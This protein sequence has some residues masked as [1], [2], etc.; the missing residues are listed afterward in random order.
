MFLL[1]QEIKQ[2][3]WLQGN[4]QGME[5]GGHR[6][7]DQAVRLRLV[8]DHMPTNRQD[9]LRRESQVDLLYMGSPVNWVIKAT[10]WHLKSDKCRC[11][12]WCG[13]L[14]RYHYICID[15]ISS[16]SAPLWD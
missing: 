9:R 12:M 2:A 3:A 11:C 16:T 15:G 6:G 8:C 13:E 10:A 1:L 4:Q 5:Q 14:I 7:V